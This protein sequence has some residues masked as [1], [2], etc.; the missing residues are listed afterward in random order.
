METVRFEVITPFMFLSVVLVLLTCHIAMYLAGYSRHA[1][2]RAQTF[3]L[4]AAAV[5]QGLGIWGLNL[6][7]F[8]SMDLPL[9]TTHSVTPFIV[10]LLLMVA[11]SCLFMY[12]FVTGSLD[13]HTLIV[14]SAI[15]IF[16]ISGVNLIGFSAFNI[17]DSQWPHPFGFLLAAA[18]AFALIFLGLRILARS[19]RT[20]YTQGMSGSFLL[21]SSVGVMHFL[22]LYSLRGS[23]PDPAAPHE[24]MTTLLIGAGFLLL[25]LVVSVIV[26][27]DPMSPSGLLRYAAERKRMV[28]FSLKEKSLFP[29]M[30]RNRHPHELAD[31][32]RI[33]AEE[34]M[35]GVC[36][37][38]L[39]NPERQTLH[40][41]G[42]SRLPAS[43]AEAIDGMPVESLRGVWETTVYRGEPV[44]V[45]DLSD[46]P[47]WEPYGRLALE[48][49]LKS[50]FW[51]LIVSGTG[52]VL[53]T[54][55][56]YYES[57]RRPSQAD[58]RILER[59]AFIMGFAIDISNKRER[60]EKKLL[61]TNGTNA[62]TEARQ[63]YKSLFLYNPDAVFYLDKEG[64]FV[65]ANRSAE[66]VIG[67]T[68][69]ELRHQIF[70]S[71]LSEPYISLSWDH[72]KKASVG[73]PQ[74]FEIWMEHKNG[75][76]VSL[77]VTC[78]PD[79]V[80]KDF[81]GLFCICQD[82]TSK[83][84]LKEELILAQN[85]LEETLCRFDGLIF[86]IV[87]EGESFIC[88]MCGGAWLRRCGFNRNA[89]V[90]KE[91]SF[92][93]EWEDR[94][95]LAWITGTKDIFGSEIFGF[96]VTVSVK[97]IRQRGQ[98]SHL[99][100]F[101]RG[102]SLSEEREHR[103]DRIGKADLDS[104]TKREREV[105]SLIALGKSNKEIAEALGISENTVKNHITSIFGKLN[106]EGRAELAATMR[107]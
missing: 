4:I 65:E 3:W 105:A 40:L 22:F 45:K 19:N 32:V 24:D 83:V 76:P 52:T 82:I 5:I 57:P 85:E 6:I 89:L 33:M 66:H 31:A 37:V 104:L 28:E 17:E 30:I 44:F 42:S 47:E 107:S 9:G 61:P 87:K 74:T 62:E 50:C 16:A 72:F 25:S 81:V 86:K 75:N 35:D 55:D 14:A 12:I 46:A 90:G 2:G 93:P 15:R 96:P 80:E 23:I 77:S 36:A 58:F 20:G 97:P 100:L 1:A 79:M 13:N 39:L 92:F 26:M 41:A 102:Y 106:V 59:L 71:L 103:H 56:V 8:L 34:E 68:V 51:C 11:S 43:Y 95:E 10:S 99:I 63:I 94:L 64:H 91:F 29:D 101:V 60:E 73:I 54:I 38:M 84:R 69:D 88:S 7:G 53:G 49:G 70:H 21:A 67:Y 18:L 48:N 98:T 27:F 78:I